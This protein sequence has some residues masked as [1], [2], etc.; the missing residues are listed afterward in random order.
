MTH[1]KRTG[2]RNSPKE[3]SAQ[4]RLDITHTTAR[5]E[6]RRRVP[7]M[8]LALFAGMIMVI[9]G[10]HFEGA[11]EKKLELAFFVPVIVYMSDCIGTETLTLFVRELALR[12]VT[13]RR[14]FLRESAVGLALGI[15]TGVP[16]ALFSY[17]WFQDI[18]LA[19]TLLLAMMANGLVAVLTGMLIP[20]AFAKLKKDPALG[21][22]E[23]TTALS[24]NVSLLIYLVVATLILFY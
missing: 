1:E 14:L 21:T 4:R 16:I 10:S 23:I 9:V 22:D 6:I 12:K 15:V 2:T 19:M 13:L 5:A 17:L 18:R 3:G 20:I 7:W 24:D 11:I 8:F